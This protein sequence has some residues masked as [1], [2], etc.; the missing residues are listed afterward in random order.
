MHSLECWVVTCWSPLADN[1]ATFVH[2]LPSSAT[3]ESRDWKS[4]FNKHL[5]LSSCRSY[6]SIAMTKHHDQ[7]NLKKK[8]FW[9]KGGELA[10]SEDESVTIIAGTVV[11]GRSW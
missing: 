9:G 7:D 2:H 4:F 8:G 10:V 1:A 11:A 6:L 5:L 3:P